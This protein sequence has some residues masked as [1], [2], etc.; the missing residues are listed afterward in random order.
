MRSKIYKA[1]EWILIGLSAVYCIVLVIVAE[2]EQWDNSDGFV[3][4]GIVGIAL[5]V[6]M[7]AVLFPMVRAFKKDDYRIVKEYA[8][9]ESYGKTYK[10][11]R[12]CFVT[13]YNTTYMAK[14]VFDKE[15]VA[16]PRR[17][18][19]EWPY[20]PQV[21][22][23]DNRIVLSV[24]LS[25]TGYNPQTGALEAYPQAAALILP[26]QANLFYLVKTF[27]KGEIAGEGAALQAFAANPKNRE[28]RFSDLGKAAEN[29]ESR[30]DLGKA[31]ESHVYSRAPV[32]WA[33]FAVAFVAVCGLGIAA[34]LLLRRLGANISEGILGDISV[35]VFAGFVAG[36]IVFA[37]N[38]GQIY[39]KLIVNDKGVCR[40]R[41][42]YPQS[43]SWER[44][45]RVECGRRLITVVGKAE[46]DPIFQD[47]RTAFESRVV[48]AYIY[49][50]KIEG[51]IRYFIGKKNLDIPVII[52]ETELGRV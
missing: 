15:A 36:P 52:R 25:A 40:R 4:W 51:S 5:A 41:I 45:E 13:V 28:S 21:S 34:M 50:P 8:K 23:S 9:A 44:V 33:R 48:I 30:S 49:K 24:S 22:V 20:V 47:G 18:R 16:C 31:A 43:L 3:P 1:I 35:G 32:L 6:L 38:K 12:S 26:L 37:A 11:N 27:Y 19:F 2:R 17:F 46:N 42:G 14:L 39:G 29:R 7:I 10:L